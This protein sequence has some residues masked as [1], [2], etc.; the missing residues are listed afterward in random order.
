MSESSRAMKSSSPAL[1]TAAMG[2]SSIGG[3]EERRPDLEGDRLDLGPEPA[4]FVPDDKEPVL[5][6]VVLERCPAALGCRQEADLAAGPDLPEVINGLDLL[7]ELVDVLRQKAVLGQDLGERGS[8]GD[9]SPCA[10]VK[11]GPG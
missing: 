4:R 1:L 2:L 9:R 6:D 8:P 10:S 7:L 5:V 3:P 11:P